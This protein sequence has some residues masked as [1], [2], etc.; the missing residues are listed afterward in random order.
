MTGERSQRQ[1]GRSSGLASFGLLTVSLLTVSLLTV[2][3]LTAVLFT[4]GDSA[5]GY[6]R[7]VVPV[8]LDNVSGLAYDGTALW[9][10]VD[11]SGR[12]A[13]V[14]PE[15]GRI[16][17]ELDFTPA[18]TGGS[19]WD[20]EALWQLAYAARQI[21]RVDVDSGA[22]LATIPAPGDGICSGMTFDGTHLWLA[23]VDERKLFQVDP[24]RGG[25]VVAAFDSDFE[26][27]GLAWDG[28]YLWNGVLVGTT[29]DHDAP[30]PYTGFV[31]QRDPR[32]DET[33]DVLP[34]QGVFAGTSDWT[35]EAGRA[36]RM[37][38][39]DGYHGELVQFSI[40]PRARRW[41]GVLLL[42]GVSN[43]VAATWI[44]AR[45]KGGR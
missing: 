42:L 7:T 15:T 5:T 6:E 24:E 9:I 40:K 26:T 38:W 34:V 10:T 13:R 25:E 8:E 37:W 21:H 12:I 43:L 41:Q 28:R 45:R 39:Y 23:N 4:S 2:S 17:A 22:V 1:R 11:G 32:A 3:L 14:D 30:A 44:L 29:E 31:Q 20:G 35:A 18:E 19:A 16:T 27:T 33:L 36:S